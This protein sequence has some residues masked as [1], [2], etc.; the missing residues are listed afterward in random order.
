MDGKL[1]VDDAPTRMLIA[2]DHALLRAGLIALLQRQPAITI[3][4]E[5]ATGEEA[6]E[7]FR[8]LQPDVLLMDL[9]MPRMDGLTAL[10][11]IRSEFGSAR[12]ILLTTFDGDE[13]IY[14]GLAAGAMGYVLKDAPP[15][16][17]VEAIRVVRSGRTWVMP[18]VGAKLASRLSRDELTE[19]EHAVL[20]E[21]AQGKSNQEISM[22]LTISTGTVK[23]HVNR[24]LDK[25]DAAD[26][27]QAV[28]TAHTR[29]LV[30]LT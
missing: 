2:D 21:L 8:R 3:V 26:R 11:A 4:G 16:A 5:A 1:Q 19:R 28:I 27:L 6:V 30:H 9:R 24:I 15:E 14:R 13:D 18:T 29:G 25:L 23:F 17:L 7:Q 20:Q 22:T 12:V 10:R